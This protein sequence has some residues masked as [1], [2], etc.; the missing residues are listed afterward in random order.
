MCTHNEL[1]K[2][3]RRCGGGGRGR[4]YALGLYAETM[5]VGRGQW[6]KQAGVEVM[7]ESLSIFALFLLISLSKQFG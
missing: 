1:V 7:E 4:G 5:G 6:K 2:V 3:T